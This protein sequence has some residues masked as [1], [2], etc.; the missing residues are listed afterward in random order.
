MTLRIKESIKQRIPG[1]IPIT[2][3]ILNQPNM[4]ILVDLSW[5]MY[6]IRDKIIRAYN[7]NPYT[8]SNDV[9]RINYFQVDL[10]SMFID[11]FNMFSNP[12]T[13]TIH[14]GPIVPFTVPKSECDT[15]VTIIVIVV[16]IVILALIIQ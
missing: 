9:L 11:H 2:I 7:I 14:Y 15:C 4:G 10:E 13:I 5:S 8:G 1:K 16:V 12:N 3:S 6:Q